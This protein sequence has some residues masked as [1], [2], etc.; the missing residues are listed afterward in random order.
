MLGRVDAPMPVIPI[1]ALGG[2]AVSGI[3][4]MSI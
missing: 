4:G 2:M 3:L 1:G